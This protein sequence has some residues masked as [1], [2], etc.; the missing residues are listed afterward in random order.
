MEMNKKYSML[1]T[2]LPPPLSVC[3]CFG[4]WPLAPSY[5]AIQ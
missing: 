5:H 2:A 1:H 3:L 4:R